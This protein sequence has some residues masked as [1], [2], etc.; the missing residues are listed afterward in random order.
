[1]RVWVCGGFGFSSGLFGVD[2]LGEDVEK[3]GEEMVGMK[4]CGGG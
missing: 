4:K 3:R 1:M 2:G